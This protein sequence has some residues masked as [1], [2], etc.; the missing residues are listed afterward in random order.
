MGLFSR[1]TAAPATPAGTAAATATRTD[2]THLTGD[3]VIDPTHSEI[4][5]SARHA[6]ITTVRGRFT[7]Y[8]GTLHLDGST[9]SASTAELSIKVASI[10]TAQAA[11]DE[12]LRNGDFFAAEEFPEIRRTNLTNGRT[13]RDQWVRSRRPTYCSV[14]GSPSPPGSWEA[15]FR[16]RDT[17]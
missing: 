16:S 13:G 11:R 9:P 1:K 15:S 14:A 8:E 12:H 17:E 4:G 10:D 3:Y 7:D 6:M 2:L 5:F